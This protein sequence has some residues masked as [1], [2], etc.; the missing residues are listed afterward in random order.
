MRVCKGAEARLEDHLYL[1]LI[2]REWERP[3]SSQP[4]LLKHNHISSHGA[5]VLFFWAYFESR[6]RR[7][8]VEGVATATD[9]LRNLVLLPHHG[10]GMMMGRLYRKVYG[11]TY[12]EDLLA[13]GQQDVAELLTKIQAVRNRFS[14]G[15]PDAI[16]DEFATH[17]VSQIENEHRAFILVFNHRVAE[18]RAKAAD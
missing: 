1:D 10:V 13:V 7:L 6:I 3:A 18:R 15:N 11:C 17:V 4:G 8:L 12:E 5:V 9:E 2:Q 16:T 14:H